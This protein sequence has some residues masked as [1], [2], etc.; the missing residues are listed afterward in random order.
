MTEWLKGKA[1]AALCWPGPWAKN[2]GAGK[3]L[4]ADLEAA[5]VPYVKDELFADFHSL[6]HS[7]VSRLIRSGVNLKVVQALARHSTIT[8]TADRYG[9]LA[10]W[11]KRATVAG[12][13]MLGCKRGW[14]QRK[15]LR[16]QVNCRTVWRS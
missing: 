1:A 15:T 12:F 6:R 14:R 9:H 5:G 13:D 10:H 8:L 11:E 3:F 4:K 16:K 2:K 7:Y